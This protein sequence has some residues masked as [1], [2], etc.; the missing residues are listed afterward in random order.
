MRIQF[1]WPGLTLAG[2]GSFGVSGGSD[3]NYI[4]HGLAML[5]AVLKKDGHDCYSNDLRSFQ[6]WDHFEKIVRRQKFDLTLIGFHSVDK[7]PALKAC[8]II[9]KYFP[10]KPIIV[11]GPHVTIA[12]ETELP[13]IDCIVWGE[14][15]ITILELL[16]DLGNLPKVITG[17]PVDNLNDLPPVDRSLFNYEFE[18]NAPLLPLLPT[19]FYTINLGRGCFY[20]CS[21]CHQSGGNPIFTK[22]WRVRSV[23]NFL[24]EVISIITGNGEM[25][26][27]F[28]IND[29]I[30]PVR[31]WCDEF[32][33]KM[34][35]KIPFWCQMRADFICKNED[36]IPKLVDV[37]LTWVSLG[38]ESGSQR[39]LDFFNKKTTVAQNKKAIE[40]LHRNN[41]NIFAN[42][43]FG[44]PTE[45]EEEF[46]MTERL[47]K[48][49]KFS[50]LSPSVYTC[51]PGSD[52]FKF[53]IDNNLFLDEHYS[54]LRY[55]YERKVKGVDYDHLFRKI[56][57]FSQYKGEL[58]QNK[59]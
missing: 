29:D 41:V 16:K 14:G 32:I 30:F 59:S 1:L 18:K 50:W 38:I 28:M 5:S 19:P 15:E 37:G 54:M 35:W 58:R 44:A 21:Y 48:E 52:L 47:I 7:D 17:K 20:S 12:Q 4:N 39:M 2:F 45:T 24:A 10:G 3:A 26:G 46:K 51:Y 43:V 31:K 49:S 11:G 42:F 8:Q 22:K 27:S 40:I 33:D 56:G 9:K 23:D 53:C 13:N 55:P 6:N 25:I 36:L 57:E 34:M